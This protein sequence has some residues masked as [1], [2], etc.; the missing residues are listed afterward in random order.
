M[1]KFKLEQLFLRGKQNYG[2]Y[3]IFFLYH[4]N[5][6]LEQSKAIELETWMEI[7]ELVHDVCKKQNMY[8]GQVHYITYHESW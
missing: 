5:Y 1:I 4:V 7:E 2:C 8:Q 3:W 6:H